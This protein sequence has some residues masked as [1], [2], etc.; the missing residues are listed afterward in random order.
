MQTTAAA[1]TTKLN[2]SPVTLLL[3]IETVQNGK[4]LATHPSDLVP[5]PSAAVFDLVSWSDYSFLRDFTPCDQAKGRPNSLFKK[6]ILKHLQTSKISR[7]FLCEKL[8]VAT[9]PV[10]PYSD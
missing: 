6:C 9:R 7:Y 1:T 2:W 8:V 4:T 10:P 5:R 3:Y